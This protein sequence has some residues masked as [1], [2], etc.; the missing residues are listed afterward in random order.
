MVLPGCREFATR[1]GIVR[2]ISV[3]KSGICAMP[4][5]GRVLLFA[6]AA[7]LPLYSVARGADPE[8]TVNLVTAQGVGEAIGTV[9]VAKTADGAAFLVNLHGLP[10]G[11]HGMHVHANGDCSPGP[12]N[13]TVVAA[14]AAGGHFDP[15]NTGKHA[16][17]TGDGHLGDLPVLD[18]L[19]DARRTSKI[20][21]KCVA[22]L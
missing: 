19:P 20:S 5:V 12:V 15:D 4:N 10:P 11:Q 16:G 8:A 3:N 18:I 6:L 21:K 9:R 1:T 14:G 7:S 17:P 13:G 22:M 2:V